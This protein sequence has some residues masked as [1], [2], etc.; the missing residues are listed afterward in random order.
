[1]PGYP[2]STK[3][4]KNAGLEYETDYTIDKVSSDTVYVSFL[5]NGSKNLE[6]LY[7]SKSVIL[8]E[9]GAGGVLDNGE[10]SNSESDEGTNDSESDEDEDES[11]S[12]LIHGNRTILNKNGIGGVIPSGTYIQFKN[13]K[14]ITI[15]GLKLTVS[16]RNLARMIL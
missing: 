6:R 7:V 14:K 3:P 12:E 8:A 5:D 1:M 15:A 16:K 2:T 4:Q 9:L 13:T 10:V 11:G